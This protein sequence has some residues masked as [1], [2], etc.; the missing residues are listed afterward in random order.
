MA[1]PYPTTTTYTDKVNYA[2]Y[3][4]TDLSAL[5]KRSD[6]T[7]EK[8]FG[9]QEDDFIELSVF[10]SQNNLNKW[11]PIIPPKLYQPR[12]IEY[13]DSKNNTIEVTYQE[14]I[15]N[16]T[17]YNQSKILLDPKTDLKN[18]GL[19]NGSYKVVYNFQSN[20]VGTSDKRCFLIKQISPSRKEIKIILLL[21][22]EN[23]SD[24][25]KINFQSEFNSYV[26]SKIETRDVL[27]D[28]EDYLKQTYL[29]NFVN[30]ASDAV[31]DSFSK[32]YSVYGSEGLYKLMDEIY[33]GV[34]LISTESNGVPKTQSFIG[35]SKY[36]MLMLYEN[37]KNSFSYDQY[38][39]ILETIVSETINLRLKTIHD[40]QNGDTE[41]CTTYLFQVFN[42]QIQS[43]LS[44]VYADYT[45]KYVG[46]LKNSIN[47]GNNQF[48][49]IL[50]HKKFLDGSLVIKLQNPLPT[51]LGINSTFWLTNT[52]LAPVVQNVVMVSLPVYNTFGIKAPNFNLKV[53]DK[54][55]STAISLN[56]VDT[57][58]ASNVD[59]TL[60]RRFST[61][62]VDYT[63]FENFI[64]YSSAQTRITV[65]KNK[66]S[67]INSKL[68]AIEQINSQSYSDA[69][70]VKKLSDLQNEIDQIKLS[71]DGYEYY[72]YTNEY[73]NSLERFPQSYVDEASDYDT[74][75]RDSLIN[76][77]P[78]YLLMDSENDE[79]LIF[80]SMIGHHFDNIYVYIDK[81][82]MLTYNQD[83]SDNYIPNNLL[84]NML[85]SF[86]WK[87]Q[88]LVND[89]SINSNYNK[90]S[91]VSSISDK[92][93]IINNRIL[94]TLPA[95]LKAKGTI[96]SVRLLMSCY[97]VPDDL[98][99]VKEFGSY[100]NIS[101]SYYSFN[102]KEY[103][104]SMNPESYIDVPTGTEPQSIEFKFAFSS[105][106]SKSYTNKSEID[107][108]RKYS[109]VSPPSNVDYRV[110]AYKSSENN[111]GQIV[112]EINDKVL[113]SKNFP[114]FDGN[115]Y[116]V[117]L[118]KND[119]SSLYSSSANPSLINTTYDLI[120]E[121][122]DD[123]ESRLRSKESM[124]MTDIEND[125]FVSGSS[126][127]IRFGST[128]FSGSID[129]INIW[130]V[131]ITD[132]NFVEHVNNFESYYQSD[133]ESIRANLYFRLSYSYPK[134]IST[135]DEVYVYS[136][137]R[138]G[139][140][141]N[142]PTVPITDDISE[143]PLESNPS[144]YQN[145]LDTRKLYDGNYST[146]SLYP[147]STICLEGPSTEFPYNFT[148]YD[149]NQS[150]R[151]S[152]Y[153]PNLLW[154]NKISI[155]DKTDVTSITPFQKSTPYNDNI[156]SNLVGIFV[157]PTTN[158]SSE[159]LKFFGDKN[160][161][162]ELGDPHLE[163]SQSY[164]PLDKFRKA[165][166]S[167]GYPAYSGKVLYQEFTSVY[168]LYIDPSIFESI[169]NITAARN[170]LLTGIL[171]EPTILERIK[172]PSKPIQSEIIEESITFDSLVQES[173]E[174]IAMLSNDI[175]QHDT[176]GT[177]DRF[178]EK[179]GIDVLPRS[180]GV[181]LSS[182]FGG[183]YINDVG[184]QYELNVCANNTT[185]NGENLYITYLDI[186]I[187]DNNLYQYSIP[188]FVWME[189]YSSSVESMDSDGLVHSYYRTFEK[190]VATQMSAYVVGS[191]PS[192]HPT[193]Y[194]PTGNITP[195]P[196]CTRNHLGHRHN[197][198][199]S[200]T[201]VERPSQL[202]LLPNHRFG[203][204]TR[205]SQ[206]SY[207][208]VDQCGD[209]DK[210]LPVVSTIVTNTSVSTNTNGV[211]TAN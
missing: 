150:Y 157:S 51:N 92:S 23:F 125:L 78:E 211:L 113:I 209:S 37:Y 124:V 148:S 118:R 109:S 102:K 83:G 151:M 155:K 73:Y 203:T 112:F 169:R 68:T 41:I 93:N 184:S 34:Q 59:L 197:P 86:G 108:I 49:R 44:S 153:G 79:F 47:F 80:L 90:G 27:P 164:D 76:N 12:H 29:L 120:V 96:E 36:I 115:V 85:E 139:H 117:L 16:F 144:L 25:D 45:K 6:I 130:N 129:K 132:D 171:I 38:S 128:M 58:Y 138:I 50:S 40:V 64:V 106:H 75:N 189:P 146:S 141:Y 202:T 39:K 152:N 162:D 143:N 21:D 3:M 65:Y 196:G 200:G 20:V 62:N 15:P 43:Y 147:Y 24:E 66:L 82:P 67:A 99:T 201:V 137:T 187:N 199:S 104:L 165:Y 46:P 183:D 167:A 17:L 186:D 31:K 123:G 42:T 107:L 126:S 119:P 136:D 176:T 7:P 185:I 35:I 2:S 69:Y 133:Y 181:T 114:I 4:P 55:T 172:F 178:T 134:K 30:V 57:S 32:A 70:I 8:F 116:S 158:K 122:N 97:G 174:N 180:N 194:Y 179:N 195:N 163:F 33:N 170:K 198:F 87:P 127:T 89:V 131:P 161:I 135:T 77:L 56:D 191:V 100:S 207:Y 28:F 188:Y 154:N 60:T 81:F 91:Y 206:T 149:I 208:T 5:V 71:F 1:F 19:T 63:S 13:Q 204:F 98:L 103:L 88:S 121:I 18:I 182:N 101:Q 105:L 140:L 190:L 177:L 26:D 193:G 111:S 10:D 192:D 72:L 22:K 210:T 168:R 175:I 84:N 61:I 94:N 54:R 166:Y 156:D 95:I 205:S 110:Y 142:I 173:G 48:Y 145:T 53:N 11:V 74:N 159:I 52:S 14:F 9:S 160:V